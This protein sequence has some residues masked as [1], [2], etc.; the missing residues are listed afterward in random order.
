MSKVD[1]S[2]D[3]YP[4]L[5]ELAKSDAYVR[6][7]IGPAG[8]AK[9]SCIVKILTMMAMLQEPDATG[10]RW[11]RWLVVRQTYQ[12]LISTTLKSF[13]NF[14]EP[15]CTYRTNPTPL[16]TMVCPLPDGTTVNAVFE[17]LSMDSP[18]SITKLLGYE[19]TGAFLDEVSELSE[20]VIEAVVSR[21]G[22]FPSGNKGTPTWTGVLGATNGPL[23][24]HWLYKWYKRTLGEESCPEWSMY[25]ESAGRKFFELFR[26]PPALIKPKEVG[27]KWLPNLE[28]ENIDNLQEG[29]A[30][31][32]KMLSQTEVRINAYVLGEFSDL[33]TGEVVF[34]E[35]KMGLHVK[36]QADVFIRNGSPILMSFDFGRTPTALVGCVTKTGQLVILHEFC[37]ENMAMSTL[38]DNSIQG[39]ITEHHSRSKIVT[40]WGDPA[41]STGGQGLELSPFEVLWQRGVP[42]AVTWNSGN[43]LEPRLQAVRKRLTSLDKNGQPMLIISD[44]C[45]Y[46]IK[47]LQTNYIYESIRGRSGEVRDTPTK[48]HIEWASDIADALQYMCLGMESRYS[49]SARNDDRINS[50]KRKN[51]WL[52]GRKTS[53]WR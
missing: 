22:R 1:L 3:G 49:Y 46:L 13:L 12:Q 32:Y 5:Q 38:W 15:I 21:V 16:I 2:L 6:I 31:Y 45:K 41:G 4:T 10:T 29:Y 14:I 28:A 19:P 8:S 33:Q 39:W 25:E 47:A 43:Q 42:I 30:Y 36:P 44:S 40:A 37:G 34:P 48:S 35:F 23:K 9:T 20:N 7:V 53:T 11:S 51:N 26:Q 52:I 50:D 18:D 17:F 24:S 27:G